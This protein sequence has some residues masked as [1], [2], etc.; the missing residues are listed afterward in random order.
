M[1]QPEARR[2]GSLVSGSSGGRPSNRRELILTAASELFH[3]DGY[4]AVSIQDIAAAAGL[5]TS[6]M[7][8]YFSSKQ[9][10][11]AA[12]V[13]DAM[14][15]IE[16]VLRT[17]LEDPD[18]DVT[19][20][21]SQAMLD[22]REIGVLWHREAR[23]LPQDTLL[24][25]RLQLRGLSVALMEFVRARQPGIG[26]AEA[27]LLAWCDLCVAA[28]VSFHSLRLP[29]PRFV[30]LLGEISTSTISAQVPELVL[31]DPV[32]H[33]SPRTWSP[34]RRE[35]ILVAAGELFSERGYG[36][37]G[38]DDIGARVGIAGPSIYNHFA[39]KADILSAAVLRAESW[40]RT[41]MHRALTRA[42]SPRD[43][44]ERLIS[45]YCA[46]VFEHSHLFWVLVSEARH[47]EPADQV[48]ARAANREYLDEWVQLLRQVHPDWDPVTARIRTYAVLT[49]AGDIAATPHLRRYSNTVD[50]MQV[51]C[52]EILDL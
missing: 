13:A 51:V 15:T 4:N 32:E 49:I 46:F 40:L 23:Y 44:L 16:A 10:V 12:V 42:T 31:A 36:S 7:Y 34:S 30:Q 19:A 48:R 29:R 39:S 25:L 22:H 11:L 41:D 28:S 8:R 20:A 1:D 14:T 26:E 35:D 2:K 3:R 21:L 6:G 50:A 9:A 47:T 5:G 33:E 45:S 18:A 43:A 27:D 24:A 38:I 52:R 37:V 17:R